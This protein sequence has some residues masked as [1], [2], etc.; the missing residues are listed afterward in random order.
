MFDRLQNN[1]KEWKTLA[2]EYEVKVKALEEE[3]RKEAERTAAKKGLRSTPA[4]AKTTQPGLGLQGPA[5][6]NRVQLGEKPAF[7]RPCGRRTRAP[8]CTGHRWPRGEAHPKGTA[9]LIQRS[10]RAR[11][12][13]WGP[14]RGL[15]R[16]VTEC[17]LLYKRKESPVEIA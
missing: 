11:G 13:A 17:Y 6:G 16:E 12:R 4:A 9:L 14:S 2:D 8:G 1:R 3:Q 15:R 5:R 7:R 10:W